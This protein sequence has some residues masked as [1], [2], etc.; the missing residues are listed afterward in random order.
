MLYFQLL[1]F[2][3]SAFGFFLISALAFPLLAKKALL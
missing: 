1:A 3:I 2:G